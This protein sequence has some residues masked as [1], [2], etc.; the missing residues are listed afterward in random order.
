[1]HGID[2]GNARPRNFAVILKPRVE[3]QVLSW[4]RHVLS[5]PASSFGQAGDLLRRRGHRQLAGWS[6]SR[7]LA[8]DPTIP[9]FGL[10]RSGHA[11][12]IGDVSPLSS[13]ELPADVRLLALRQ[14]CRRARGGT[15]HIDTVLPFL[16]PITRVGRIEAL[17]LNCSGMR[18]FAAISC[19]QI[20]ALSGASLSLHPSMV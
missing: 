3:R 7:G 14:I 17:Y 16:Q 11:R 10:R 18:L 2:A 20:T 19:A 1:M 9:A 4:S 12:G 8:L 13:D 15:D 5:P 6:S